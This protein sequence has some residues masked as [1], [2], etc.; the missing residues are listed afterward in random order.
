MKRLNVM[1]SDE[2]FEIIKEYQE[3]NK[4]SKRDDAV[5]AYIKGVEQK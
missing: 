1:I 4:F 5:D 2:S 3:K